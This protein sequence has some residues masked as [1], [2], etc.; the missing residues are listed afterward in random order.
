[1]ELL[2]SR[3][4]APLEEIGKSASGKGGESADLKKGST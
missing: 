3:R 1:M 2:L 4:S